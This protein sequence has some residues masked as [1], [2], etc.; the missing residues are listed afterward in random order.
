M[1]LVKCPEC[2]KEISDKAEVCI[3]CGYPLSGNK[4]NSSYTCT[5]DGKE[6]DFSN[7]VDMI[8]SGKPFQAMLRLPNKNS[9]VNKKCIPYLVIYYEEHKSFPSELDSSNLPMSDKEIDKLS[10]D[11][12][13]RYK[14]EERAIQK[15]K[16]ANTIV[17]C[18]KCGSTNIQLIRKKF[19]L[20]TGFATNK[21]ERVCA[22]CLHK[23]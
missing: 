21:V 7:V 11:I 17:T 16:N 9:F 2:G 23:F 10:T 1:S 18:P 15:T 5:I 12:L 4:I 3:H 20:L 6:Y 13:V 19:S 8:N 14:R 22:N